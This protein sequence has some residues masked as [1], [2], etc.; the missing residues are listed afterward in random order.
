MERRDLGGWLHEAADLAQGIVSL[1]LLVLI[2]KAGEMFLNKTHI[3][4]L[5]GPEQ[6]NLLYIGKA[7]EKRLGLRSYKEQV[8][9]LAKEIKNGSKKQPG[10][11][12][13]AKATAG[14]QESQVKVEGQW[15][16]VRFAAGEQPAYKRRLRLGKNEDLYMWSDAGECKS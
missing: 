4:V 7:E 8:E 16:T 15:R 3:D 10:A 11:V 13:R 5:Q 9:N 1:T 6:G 14:L 12:K 2:T